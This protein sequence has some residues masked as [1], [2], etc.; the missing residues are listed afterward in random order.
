M[1]IESSEF[2]VLLDA[3][4]TLLRRFRIIVIEFHQMEMV[5]ERH[6]LA[7]LRLILDKLAL[8]FHPVH[9]HPNNAANTLILDGIEVPNVFEVTYYR[10]DRSEPDGAA[11][12]FPHQLD[13]K[14]IEANEDLVLPRHWWA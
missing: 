1:D 6:A 12:S 5:F 7:F 4:P 11:L 9:V 10:K 14:N 3:S 8:D 13:R 2:E